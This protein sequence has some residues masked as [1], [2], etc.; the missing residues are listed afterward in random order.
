MT[1]RALAGSTLSICTR[2]YIE[3]PTEQTLVDTPH[4]QFYAS[5]VLSL[6]AIVGSCRP[7]RQTKGVVPV[8]SLGCT[9]ITR[10]VRGSLGAM[11]STCARLGYGATQQL[12][13]PRP[14]L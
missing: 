7:Q 9:T 11:P 3:L 8:R 4:V 1:C 13:L 2:T 10:S 14:G 5:G 6:H 12:R